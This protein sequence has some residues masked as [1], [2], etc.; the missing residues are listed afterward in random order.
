[1]RDAVVARD[2]ARPDLVP[3]RT[4]KSEWPASSTM[5][6]SQVCPVRLRGEP[7]LIG[8]LVIARTLCVSHQS[9]RTVD[10]TTARER[11]PS[12]SVAIGAQRWRTLGARRGWLSRRPGRRMRRS[13]MREACCD[14]RFTATGMSSLERLPLACTILIA[15]LEPPCSEGWWMLPWRERRRRGLEGVLFQ[16][17]VRRW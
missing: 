10:D 16:R 7:P 5:S 1:M 14:E 2:G 17:R 9:A 4:T 6:S 8:A 11:A 15:R 3:E 12:L 13:A